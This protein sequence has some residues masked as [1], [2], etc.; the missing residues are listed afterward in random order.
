MNIS[1]TYVTRNSFGWV[2]KR[3]EKSKT[4]KKKC[5]HFSSSMP[6]LCGIISS[7]HINS[8][9][10]LY[11]D[12]FITFIFLLFNVAIALF[13]FSSFQ[14]FGEYFV[15]GDRLVVHRLQSIVQWNAPFDRRHVESS[16]SGHRSSG[17]TAAAKR[18]TPVSCSKLKKARNARIQGGFEFVSFENL[19][20][21][22]S[23]S[24]HIL[25]G[26]FRIKNE[27]PIILLE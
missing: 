12:R 24:M 7:Q 17:L 3:S 10:C 6:N 4:E 15:Q 18:R 5:V 21:S 16:D 22:M 1:Y 20:N 13:W 25:T 8:L 19:L 2:T 26:L 23:N 27:S 11:T 14:K 9:K